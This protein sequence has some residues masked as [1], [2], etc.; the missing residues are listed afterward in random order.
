MQSELKISG[1][2]EA[3][4][5]TAEAEHWRQVALEAQEAKEAAARQIKQLPTLHK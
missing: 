3:A 5:A 4:R 1:I 2:I